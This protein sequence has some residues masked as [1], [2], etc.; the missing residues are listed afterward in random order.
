VITDA[1]F[2]RPNGERLRAP[3]LSFST[4]VG[5]N[6]YVPFPDDLAP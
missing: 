2:L 4:L 6:G 3:Q 5:G 1:D